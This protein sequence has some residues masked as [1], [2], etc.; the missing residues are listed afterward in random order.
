M[1]FRDIQFNNSNTPDN[2]YV[3][4]NKKAEGIEVGFEIFE[5]ESTINMD[6]VKKLISF[7]EKV[8]EDGNK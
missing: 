7:L 4:A 8:V 5:F 3:W 1:K 2:M 6:E